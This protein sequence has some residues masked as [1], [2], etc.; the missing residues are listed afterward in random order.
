VVYG[1]CQ[2][3]VRGERVEFATVEAAEA[4]AR[5]TMAVLAVL[6]E[7]CHVRLLDTPALFSAAY[8]PRQHWVKDAGERTWRLAYGQ[9]LEER[10][11]ATVR[12]LP[13]AAE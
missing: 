13:A 9:P 8:S 4:W 7:R 6:H 5:V 1:Y 2:V 12:S 10:A 3:G 11:P